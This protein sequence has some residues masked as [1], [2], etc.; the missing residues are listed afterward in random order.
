MISGSLSPWHGMSSGMQMEEW[1]PIWRVAVNT[2]N[3]QLR[4]ADKEWS[5][6]LEVGWVLTTPNCK[7][8]PC[9]ETDTRTLGLD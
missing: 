3:K 8:L 7:N 1:P 6:R 9:Y 4:T 2:S 5:S